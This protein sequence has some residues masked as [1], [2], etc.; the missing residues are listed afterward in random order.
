MR[1][2][3]RQPGR[4]ATYGMQLRG[5]RVHL[6]VSKAQQG[7]GFSSPFSLMRGRPLTRRTEEIPEF[8]VHCFLMLNEKQ[9]RDRAIRE[10][11]EIGKQ[12]QSLTTDRD[13]YRKLESEVISGNS[14]LANTS[15]P[16]LAMIRGAYTDATTMRLRRLFAP[17]ANLSLRRLLSQVPEYPDMLHDKLTGK[18]LSAD[19]TELDRLWTFLKEHIDPHF[20][21]HERTPAAVA[22]ANRELDRAIDFLSDCVKRY[23][24]IV[25]ESYIELDAS[26]A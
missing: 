23:Y 7:D 22:M 13:L 5:G 6:E 3:S 14:L 20:S 25:S 4:C 11:R 15:S 16:Y 9:F 8:S 17:D 26:Y 24:W 18:E 2:T 12:V 21:N 10:L 1:V 19:L